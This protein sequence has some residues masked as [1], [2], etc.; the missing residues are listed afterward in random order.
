MTDNS[1]AATPDNAADSPADNAADLPCPTRSTRPPHRSAPAR[2]SARTARPSATSTSAPTSSHALADVGIVKTF[3][4]QELTLPVALAG[5]DLIG[6]ART[7]TGKTLGFGVPL[8]NRITLPG[9]DGAAP[10]AL[11]IA[12]TRELAVQVSGDL[13]AAGEAHRRPRAH[14]L[15]RTGLRAADRG[16]AQGHRRRRRHPGSTARPG[17]AGPPRAGQRPHP[18]ARRGR[19]D[20]RP[21]FP[22][23]HR[24]VDEDAAR[25]AADHAVLGDHARADRGACAVVPEPAAADPRRDRRRPYRDQPRRPVR[26]PGARDG[27][28]GAAVAGAAGTRSRPDDDLRAYQALGGQDRRRADRSRLRGRGR[29][30]RSRAGCPRAG[31]ARVPRRARSTCSSPPTSPPAAWT[32]RASRT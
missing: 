28:G 13:A 6:Q 12:P 27:Q 10:Q 19:R 2:R 8:L 11:V 3:A 1:T 17:R 29:A 24:E 26:L 23:G 18:G 31:A 30:R 25:Q 16:L 7:G 9:A 20:A 5:K 4:I 32:S 22:A 14:D 15:R 21:G